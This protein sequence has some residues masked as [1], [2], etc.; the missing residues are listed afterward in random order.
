MTGFPPFV[1]RTEDGRRIVVSRIVRSDVKDAIQH[2]Q[3]L[4]D[5]LTYI[6]TEHVSAEQRKRWVKSVDDREVL[7]IK[8]EISGEFVGSLSLARYGNLEKS[9]HLR[10]LGM[11]VSKSLRGMGVGSALMDYAIGWARRKGLEK[12][13]LGVFSTNRGAIRFY[14]KFGFVR[15]GVMKRQFRIQGKYVDEIAMAKFL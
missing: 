7:W 1:Y 2:W 6:A 14:E 13:T 3:A 10:V 5:E 4:A 15:E 11:G 8:A 12:I 9:R